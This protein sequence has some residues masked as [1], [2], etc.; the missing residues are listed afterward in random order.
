MRVLIF[1]IFLSSSATATSAQETKRNFFVQANGW[2]IYTTG[3][4][5]CYAFNRDPVEFDASPYNALQFR[6]AFGSKGIQIRVMLWPGAVAKKGSDT[7]VLQVDKQPEIYLPV[8]LN[9][10]EF[11]LEASLGESHL[12]TLKFG[13][14]LDARSGS[15]VQVL[16]NLA[17]LKKTLSYLEWCSK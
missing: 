14:G 1:L 10:D 6:Q 9:G 17:A 13:Q 2:T 3:T 5:A 8:E 7:L 16:F 11:S 4:A 15:S 12:E